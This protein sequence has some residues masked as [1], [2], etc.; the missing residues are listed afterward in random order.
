MSSAIKVQRMGLGDVAALRG[1]N[2]LF[3]EVFDDPGSYGSAPAG[4]RLSHAAR[5]AG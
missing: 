1:M 2:K 3:G 5:R 4:R